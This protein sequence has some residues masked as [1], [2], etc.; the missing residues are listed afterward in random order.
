MVGSRQFSRILLLLWTKMFLV[1]S[2]L[3]CIYSLS[4]ANFTHQPRIVFKEKET[5]AKRFPLSGKHEQV[6]ILLGKEPNTVTTVGQTHLNFYNF[7]NPKK[8]PVE[9]KVEWDKC[10]KDCSYNI[11]LVSQREEGKLPF[12][13]GFNGR[14]TVC[15]DLMLT[16]DP[17][18]CVP[19]AKAKEVGGSI[20]GHIIKENEHSVLIETGQSADLYI[21]SSGARE[22]AGIHKFG[23]RRVRPAPHDKEQH[24]VGLVLSQRGGEPSQDRIYAFYKQKNKDRGLYS[25]MWLPFVS[26]VCMTDIGGPKNYMQFGWTSQM[27]TRLFCGDRESK[28]HFSELVNVATL[29]AEQWQN[30]KVYALFRNEWGM[31]A[32]CVYTIG[33]IHNIFTSS[34]FKGGEEMNRTR[35]CVPDSTRISPE[36]LRRIEKASEMEQ[37]VQPMNNSGPL[38]FNHHS[39]T[40]IYVDTSVMF[41]SLNSGGIHKVMQSESHSFIIAEYRSFPDRTHIHG[42][43]FNPLTGKL[44]VNSKNDL[45]QLDVTNCALYGNT[46]QECVLSRDPHCGWNGKN[47]TSETR[48]TQQDIVGGNHTTCP[49]LKL[50]RVQKVKPSHSN[51][52]V[53]SITL[54][55]KS[56]YFLR[57]PML[58]HHAQYTWQSPESSMSC[59]PRE[60]QCLHLIESMDHKQEGHYKC[61]SEEMGYSK[62]LA[63]YQLQV[64][65]AAVVRTVSPVVWVCVI[66]VL[67]KS[68]CC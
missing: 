42:L 56:K 64:R 10:N 48:G 8:T 4:A 1:V 18:K 52:D 39:Y 60:E 29:H 37:W 13:C 53:V 46:C 22:Y 16:E 26:Q 43:V 20:N 14:E 67:M 59:S 44:Y 33:D 40:H 35:M 2:V 28:Q 65:G 54:P 19:S 34:P 31:S 24:Y 68:F 45:V 57:C 66:A 50:Y 32:V 41:L 36:I 55:S 27:N 23:R 25:E 63:Q 49:P 30:T 5:A 21:T 62:V 9:R 51:S 12:V 6:W 7:Q 61:V 58:S 17:P 11:T 38:L 15:C 3:F 47:C